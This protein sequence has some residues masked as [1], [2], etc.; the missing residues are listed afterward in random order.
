MT[1]IAVRAAGTSSA[2]SGVIYVNG[3]PAS[4]L[5]AILR[6]CRPAEPKR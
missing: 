6:L 4:G 5:V 1:G 2:V 3:L